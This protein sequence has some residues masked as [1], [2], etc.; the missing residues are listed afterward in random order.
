MLLIKCFN[1]FLQTQY[2]C[3]WCARDHKEMALNYTEVPA[4]W[5]VQKSGNEK[6]ELRNVEMNAEMK[7]CRTDPRLYALGEL[8]DFSVYIH[9]GYSD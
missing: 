5:I 9:R 8:R 7:E 3:V 4:E 6:L 1:S 2:T